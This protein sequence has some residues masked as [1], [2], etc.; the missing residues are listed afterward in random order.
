MN[1]LINYYLYYYWLLII[2]IIINKGSPL[3]E[4]RTPFREPFPGNLCGSVLRE[5]FAGKLSKLLL[6]IREPFC[7]NPI[8]EPF[9]GNLSK[10]SKLLLVIN[11]WDIDIRHFLVFLVFTFFTFFP[12]FTFG[13]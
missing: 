11:G 13:Y 8:R 2:I 10:L 1:P 7:G 5:P 3:W 9:A 12:F 6:G 4:P